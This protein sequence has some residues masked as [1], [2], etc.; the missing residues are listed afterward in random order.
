MPCCKFDLQTSKEINH[1]FYGDAWGAEQYLRDHRIAVLRDSAGTL[2]SGVVIAGR[3]DISVESSNHDIF[4][5]R[6]TP[7]NKRNHI[8]ADMI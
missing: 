8:S 7:F 1:E 6:I 5:V 4:F 3:K 2:P